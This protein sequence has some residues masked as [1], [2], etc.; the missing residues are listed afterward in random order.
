MNSVELYTINLGASLKYPNFK[1]SI[2]TRLILSIPHWQCERVTANATPARLSLDQN[3]SR[4]TGL[5]LYL[6]QRIHKYDHIKAAIQHI[7]M[8]VGHSHSV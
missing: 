6:F 2:D 8:K 4:H 3:G 5:F 1:S 7:A